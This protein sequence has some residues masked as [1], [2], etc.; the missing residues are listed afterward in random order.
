[1][2]SASASRTNLARFSSWSYLGL[3]CLFALIAGCAV[4][5]YLALEDLAGTLNSAYQTFALTS[6]TILFPVFA[7]LTFKIARQVLFDNRWAIW[8]Q[9]GCV[10]YLNPGYFKVPC[11]D[12]SKMS[13]GTDNYRREGIALLLRDGSKKFLFT[14]GLSTSDDEIM[15]RLKE[16]TG[17]A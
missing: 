9:N 17:L 3:L 15:R 13:F 11:V 10:I 4:S 8:I 5:W 6:L 12:I 1:M 7:T 16:I 14:G 2:S